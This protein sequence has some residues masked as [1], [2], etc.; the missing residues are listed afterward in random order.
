VN[1]ISFVVIAL[2][3]AACGK[4]S[5]ALERNRAGTG[6]GTLLVDASI[7]ASTTS[8]AL[9]SFQVDLQDGLGANVSGAT[10]TI[11]NAEFGDVPLVEASAGSGKYVNSKAA[12][13]NADFG[14]DVSHPTK[15]AVTGVVVGNPGM[16]VINAPQAGATVPTG[17][18]QVSWTTPTTA[19]SAAVETRDFGPAAAPDTGTYT[20]A[21][22]SNPANATQ[23]LD[24]DR[25][26]MVNIAG[27]LFGSQMKVTSS[28]RVTY[29]Q[30]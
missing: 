26:N 17:A 23:R 6:S 15:G 18:L 12:I 21:A 24:V 20:I 1:R 28:V 22:A 5:T 8:G 27:G 14:L 2:A 4:Q 10:V 7:D 25:Y 16:H 11:H 9:T 29:I 30:Q 13:S 19:Y 3:L